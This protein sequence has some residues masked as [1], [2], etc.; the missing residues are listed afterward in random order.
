MHGRFVSVPLVTRDAALFSRIRSSACA[1]ASGR[2]IDLARSLEAALEASEARV[3]GA[4]RR[5]EARE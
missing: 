2:L 3:V 4:E 5:E 1:R